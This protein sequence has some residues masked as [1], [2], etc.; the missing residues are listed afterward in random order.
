M[1]YLEEYT[2][3]ILQTQGLLRQRNLAILRNYI[4]TTPEDQLI[5]AINRINMQEQL[6]I[7]W[8]AGLH[9]PLQDAVLRRQQELIARRRE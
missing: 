2:W 4:G 5:F 9:L 7:L 1:S 8:E 6:K 3:R